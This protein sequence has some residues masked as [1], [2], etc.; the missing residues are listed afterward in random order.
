MSEAKYIEIARSIESQID[1]G[2][3]AEG[4]KL[5]THRALADEFGTTPMTIAKAYK[6]LTEKGRIESFV[7]RG[8]FVKV[9]TGLKRAIHSRPDDREWNFSILQPCYAEH[10]EA[11]HE[12]LQQ[13]FSSLTNP[14]FYGYTEDSGLIEHRAAG[15]QWMQHYG[16]QTRAPEQILLTNG[17]QHALSILIELYTEPGDCIA[18]DRWTYPGILSI[19]SFLGRQVVGVAMD[20]QGMIPDALT[21]TCRRH[22]PALV[23]LIPSHQNPT[24]ITLSQQRRE[25]LAEV[26]QRYP[27][28]LVEDDIYAFLN[29][30]ANQAITNLLPEKSFCISSL[31]KAVSPGLRCGYLKAPQSQVEKL[32]AYIR[33]TVW[34]PPPLMFEVAGNLIES[35]QAF[36]MARKQREIAR[37]RQRLARR[38][39]GGQSYCAQDTSYHLWLQ[40]PGDWQADQFA[41]TARERGMLVSSGAYFNTCADETK[42]VRLSLIA[43]SD[44][45]E[46]ERGLKALA[47]LLEQESG[48]GPTG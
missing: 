18:V 4:D 40:L 41:L 43:I 45:S 38:I 19:A 27:L 15:M 33:A 25:Q 36:E 3:Y 29:T 9:R 16:V 47:N 24:T 17:A 37:R 23:I 5:P 20:D 30:S 22:K 34:L 48:S 12:Q 46:L 10:V 6:L 28:W 39:L 2:H 8:S 7:G 1:I 11:L 26:I 14:T 44:E 32:A 13:S 21:E 31:S 42:S 35:N